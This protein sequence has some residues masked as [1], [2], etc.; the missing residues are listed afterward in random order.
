MNKVGQNIT[1]INFINVLNSLLI[2][3]QYVKK[4]GH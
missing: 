2:N 4:H 3:G 1:L